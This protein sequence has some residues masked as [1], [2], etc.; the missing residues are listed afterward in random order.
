MSKIKIGVL[1]GRFQTPYL[2]AGHQFIIEQSL[3]KYDYLMIALGNTVVKDSIRNPLD[4]ETR[5]LMIKNH[6][7]SFLVLSQ[8]FL[9]CFKQNDNRL[10]ETW[11]KNL[12]NI[13]KFYIK[14]FGFVDNSNKIEI[15]LI[16]G[17]DNFSWA[18]S[19]KYPIKEFI[20][21]DLI[22]ENATEIREEFSSSPKDSIDF[23]S[24]VIYSV[25]RQHNKVYPT[26]DIAIIDY[27]NNKFVL[28]RKPGNSLWQFPGGFADPKD[29]SFED[30]AKREAIEECGDIDIID[31]R[32][33]CSMKIDDWRYRKENSKV[34]TNFFSCEYKGGDLKPNDDLEFVEWHSFENFDI[35]LL[36]E[37]HQK[38]FKHLQNF[39]KIK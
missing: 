11:S 1:V 34:I 37:E 17:K 39:I 28:G 7:E 32:Y 3:K 5:E 10:N 24:G 25:N 4:F 15:E 2:H 23:R 22:D 9:G 19:G 13:K 12:D 20:N 18:Y 21:N 29:D 26:V 27:K 38:L 35:N 8:K 14:N 16:G 36:V 6:I 30:A 31:F 33:I